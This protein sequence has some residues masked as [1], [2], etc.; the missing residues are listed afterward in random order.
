MLF[1]GCFLLWEIT[2]RQYKA[3]L[4]LLS[5]LACS[6]AMPACATEYAVGKAPAIKEMANPAGE[7]LVKEIT[8]RA[9]PSE[10]Q[11]V[12]ILALLM[13]TWITPP[14]YGRHRMTSRTNRGAE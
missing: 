9:A 10:T 2:V 8:K 13:G 7:A 4:F 3:T 5:L 12:H 6:A 14:P 1:A 11:N